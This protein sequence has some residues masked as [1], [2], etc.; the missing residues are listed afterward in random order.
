[1]ESQDP[2]LATYYWLLW[3]V[4]LLQ[5]LKKWKYMSWTCLN[6]RCVPRRKEK[7]AWP[8]VCIYKSFLL[9]LQLA[10][11]CEMIRFHSNIP[12]TVTLRDTLTAEV[13]LECF[14]PFSYCHSN[15]TGILSVH[16]RSLVVVFL[17]SNID[18]PFS[19]RGPITGTLFKA[20]KCPPLLSGQ[21]RGGRRIIWRSFQTPLGP[22]LFIF[23][24]V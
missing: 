15:S 22:F 18:C 11:W 17:L 10:F 5:Y 7:Y 12:H 9:V 23:I 4:L 6:R 13:S 1:M 14:W 21:T 8:W 3:Y 2:N 19:V 16:T 20:P 24:R